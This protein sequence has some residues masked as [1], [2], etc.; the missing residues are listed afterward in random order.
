M[1]QGDRSCGKV[2]D[3]AA[4]S[5]GAGAPGWLAGS[6]AVGDQ[7]VDPA[8]EQGG[9]DRL[10]LAAAAGDADPARDLP[11]RPAVRPAA[12]VAARHRG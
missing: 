11:Q 10:V 3:I 2:S 5:A 6:G 12:E 7:G 9:P 8:A 4:G 1:P